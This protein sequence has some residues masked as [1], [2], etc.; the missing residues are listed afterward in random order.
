MMSMNKPASSKA[1][2]SAGGSSVKMGKKKPGKMGN[3]GTAGV[4]S[5]ASPAMELD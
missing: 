1:G 3:K 4:K 5:P 2:S